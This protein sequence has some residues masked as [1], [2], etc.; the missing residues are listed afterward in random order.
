M[1]QVEFIM[2]AIGGERNFTTF[3]SFDADTSFSWLGYLVNNTSLRLA[4]SVYVHTH[5][6]THLAVTQ[7]Y[8]FAPENTESLNPFKG[9]V[10]IITFLRIG[11]TFLHV[12]FHLHTLV[13]QKVQ[14]RSVFWQSWKTKLYLK[15]IGLIYEHF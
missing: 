13:F 2:A 11:C 5:A 10:T 3:T 9:M 15:D 8:D 4:V 1:C 12:R 6:P 14:L 7:Q